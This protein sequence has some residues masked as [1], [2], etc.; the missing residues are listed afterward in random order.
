MSQEDN[1][2][3]LRSITVDRLNKF[4]RKLDRMLT[5]KMFSY[6][7]SQRD[8]EENMKNELNRFLHYLEAEKGFSPNT[9]I[10][11]RIDL[12]RGLFPFLFRMEK[13][14]IGEV[15]KKDIRA[16]MDYLLTR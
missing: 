1:N 4:C 14:D 16:Y 2:E 8:K 10:A 13:Y 15:T 3:D 5:K 12:S 6:N 11:Y 7:F 9:I